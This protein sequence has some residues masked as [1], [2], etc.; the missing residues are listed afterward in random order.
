VPPRRPN[1]PAAASPS[2]RHS[3]AAALTPV[4]AAPAFAR[5]PWAW[6][7]LLAVF[8]LLAACMGAPLGEAVAEDFD[9]LHRAL[10]Q[11]TGTYLD[12]GGS[13]A[14]WRPIAHQLYY[15][16]LGGLIVTHPM[17][18]A[19]IHAALLALGSVLLYRAFRLVW[20]GPLAFVAATFPLFAESTRTLIGWPSHFVD[21]GLFIGLAVAVH[22]TSRR[23]LP[24]A[25]AGLLFALLCKE[26]AVI[27][28]VLLPF[29][30]F[31]R[32]RAERVRWAIACASLVAVW[33]GVYLAVRQH[34]H[35]ALP[36]GIENDPQL[37]ATPM[38]QRFAWAL[39]G[40]LRA[41]VS[42][43]IVADAHDAIALGLGLALPLF[44]GVLVMTDA[45]ARA[46]LAAMR[47]WI[48]WGLAWSLFATATLM[49]IFPLWQPN[50]SHLAS[51]GLGVATTA[52][53]GAVHPGLA[54]AMLGGRL[55]MLALAPRA[56]QVIVSDAPAT[57]AFMDFLK[58][59]RLQRF[60]RE[61]RI[62]LHDQV[63]QPPRGS[64]LVE[65]N[66]PRGL[67]YAL[68]GDHALQV[69]YRDTTLHV[70]NAARFRASSALAAVAV[71]QYQPERPRREIVLFPPDGL[72]AEDLAYHTVLAGNDAAA[73]PMIA[74]ADSFAPDT[75]LIVFHG[76]NAGLR[77]LAYFHLQRY[78]D[79]ER[80]ARRALTIYPIDYNAR[81]A[82][83][84][85]LIIGHRF[86][87]AER[88][89]ASLQRTH[90][91]DAGVK[92]LA[93]EFAAQRRS[94]AAEARH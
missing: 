61:A 74:R 71:M 24:S 34:A 37:L 73:L 40:S 36:H 41:I 63:P 59:T 78:G 7:S 72:R 9:F 86:D 87:E 77:S 39:A 56:P 65:A 18:V 20:E 60:M 14:F 82:L 58:L 68:G 81:V 80:E 43:P 25:L 66:F 85:V 64:Y 1:K 12:G 52:A 32:A 89:I 15:Q 49:P 92:S 17:A 44:A 21:L 53:L 84:A 70:I 45:G 83:A 38:T 76:N 90:A 42:L 79:A 51:M 8:V 33:G 26:V 48:A 27:A 57:G 88:V 28:A 94:A 3:P 6:A 67:I 10:L 46:R 31:P 4:S 13:S 91:G 35:L 19:A 29:L 2:R 75:S 50:R 54:A 23:R 47:A 22:E 69:W 11:G 93:N 5:D 62:A 55:V 30:P 16:L